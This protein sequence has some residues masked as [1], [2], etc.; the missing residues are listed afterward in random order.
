[1]KFTRLRTKSEPF[2]TIKLILL[3]LKQKNVPTT[4]P[5]KNKGVIFTV[6]KIP[7]IEHTRK[8]VAVKSVGSNSY[9]LLSSKKLLNF[10]IGVTSLS[11][12]VFIIAYK[13]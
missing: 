4:E 5:S 13:N 7:R 10:F 8:I 12:V 3:H 1:M 9:G 11:F 2:K 6:V